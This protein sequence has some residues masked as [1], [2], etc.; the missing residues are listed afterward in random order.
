MFAKLRSTGRISRRIAIIGT[1][2]HAVGLMHTYQR[3]PEL[4][5]EVAAAVLTRVIS[6]PGAKRLCLDLGH[7]AVAAE[8]PLGRRVRLPALPGD[9]VFVSQ[10][11]EHLVVETAAA[12]EWAIGDAL[13]GIPIHI[14]PTVA[15]HMEAVLIAD[16]GT[17]TG[18]AWKVAAR[19]RRITI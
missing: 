19:D 12:G 2:P 4:G 1:D 16:D 8:N 10:S 14:C 5:Y 15:L 11:E 17:P 13:V 18:E 3:H 6:K 9:L 7:K